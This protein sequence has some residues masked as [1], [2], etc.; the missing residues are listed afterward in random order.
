MKL[1]AISVDPPEISKDFAKKIASDGKGEV[2]FPILSDPDHKIIDAYGLR[3][4]A[5]EGQKFDG[6]PHPAV[7]VIDK[8]GHVT[9]A[10]IESNYRERPAIDEIYAALEAL[11]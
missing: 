8:T 2:N 1:Y 9:W 7:Y 11:K 4:P 3:D 5:Y 10:R 6:I